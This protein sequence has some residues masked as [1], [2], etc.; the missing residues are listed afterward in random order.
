MQ[1]ENRQKEQVEE[2]NQKKTAIAKQNIEVLEKVFYKDIEQ[3]EHETKE[4][5]VS[6]DEVERR[7]KQALAIMEEEQL[8]KKK[9]WIKDERVM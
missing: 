2:Y 7:K 6:E 3:L 5:S 8:N 4:T 9:K 1:A